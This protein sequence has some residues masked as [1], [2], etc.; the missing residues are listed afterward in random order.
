LEIDHICRNRR[1]VRPEHLRSVTRKQNIENHGGAR[2]D[3]KSGIR[4]VTWP[5]NSKTWIATFQHDGHF[6][7]LGSFATKE[8]AAEVVLAARLKYFTHNELDRRAA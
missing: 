2:A 3:R 7:H 8:E 5:K 1:C 4:G 6:Q